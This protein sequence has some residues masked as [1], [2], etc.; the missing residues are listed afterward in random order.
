MTE[1]GLSIKYGDIAPGAKENFIAT[2]SDNEFDTL[3]QLNQY[4]LNF[5]NYVNPCEQ[6]S[7]LLD[8]NALAFPSEVDNINVG[9]WSKQ[10]SNDDGIFSDPIILTLQSEGQY[11]SQGFTFTFDTYNN[12]Y[13]TRLNIQWLRNTDDGIVRLAEQEFY[14]DNASYFC[15]K[16][17]ENYNKVIITFY[18][19]NMPCNRLKIRIVDYGYGTIF[20]GKELRNTRIS[21]ALDPISSQLSIN[22]ADIT[23]DSKSDIVYS[24][25]TRQPLSVY[26][27]GELKTTTFVKT[28][29]RKSQNIWDVQ[30][31]DY[32]GLME[33]IP[34][35]GGMY[36]D[37]YAADIIKD[38]FD[39]AKIPYSIS[40]IFN[41]KKVT[42]YIPFTNCRE[43]LRQVVF[44]IAGAVKTWNSEIVQ[45]IKLNNELEQTLPSTRIMQGQSY[46]DEDTVTEVNISYHRYN[47]IN[48]VIEAY[49]ASEDGI[50]D[51]ILIKFSEPLHNLQIENGEI[52]SSGVNY[53]IINA[54]NNCILSGSKYEHIIQTKRKKNNVVLA[55][56]IERV[57]SVSNA[58]LVSSDNVDSI[59]D[60][61][62]SWLT[63]TGSTSLKIINGKHVEYGQRIKYGQKKYGQFKYGEKTP[64]VVTYDTP[65]EIGGI[66]E[67][68]SNYNEQIVGRVISE[69]YSLNGGVIAKEAVVK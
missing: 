4:N 43:A 15:Q 38:I 26:F 42:G 31:E 58:T 2:S 53:A 19:I 1:K 27:N 48:E 8:G 68:Q 30:C 18:S 60:N 14:P 47:P 5:K 28:S 49:N 45:I 7:L 13:A 62:F 23:I 11:S 67:F 65:V 56:D 40:N 32:I 35:Y 6:Y 64:N 41:D 12:I 24:F 29:K 25:Q 54:N 63:K 44:A 10:I 69:K 17:V 61:C 50:G 51:E 16:Q 3:T 33:S 52:L 20:Y 21:N 9:M 39:T 46:T 22:T 37:E 57:M 55:S 36:Y 66:I 34:F 59:L